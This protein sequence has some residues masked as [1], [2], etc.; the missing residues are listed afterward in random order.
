MSTAAAPRRR[1]R[2][3]RYPTGGIGRSRGAASRR[4]RRPA[5]RSRA[6]VRGWIGKTA[7]RGSGLEQ[8]HQRPQ[9]R[10]R[11]HV[12]GAVGGH[13][14]VLALHQ[15][16]LLERTGALPCHRCEGQRD[17]GHHVAHQVHPRAD[18]LV[19]EVGDRR[20]RRA[21]EEV[22]RVVAQHAVQLLGHRTVARAH[23]RLHVG[24][25]ARGL[26]GRDR[27]RQRRARVAVDENEVGV[28][29]LEMGL[30]LGEDAGGL[31]GV[32]PG[33]RAE[34][35]IGGGTPSSSK[36]TRDRRSS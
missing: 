36:K 23:A 25:R 29:L 33:G 27:A 14:H 22:A 9:P 26:R 28:E 10:A 19:L 20:R 17:V 8:L 2:K 11:V 12:P 34:L 35:A 32:G 24:H 5:A 3:S 21:Q 1:A 30:E 7:G 13:Q 18:A 16:V 4:S 15:V 31:G 6:S